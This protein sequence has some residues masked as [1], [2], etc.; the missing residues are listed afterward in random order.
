MDALGTNLEYTY[1]VTYRVEPMD[2]LGAKVLSI[3]L[4]S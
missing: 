3:Y 1:L 4:S 2:A